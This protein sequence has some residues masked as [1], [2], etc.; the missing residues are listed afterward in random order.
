MEELKSAINWF[1]IPTIDF[2]RAVHFYSK[3]YDFEMPTRDMGHL[4]MGFFPH[5]PGQGIGG[6]IVSGDGYAPSQD[7][8][9]LYLN[10]GAD[11]STVLERVTD[12]GGLVVTGKTE[13]SPD[14]GHFAIIDDSEGNR[15]YLHSMN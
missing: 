15:V 2:D 13:I 10:G 3:I 9:K 11:L 6:A 8:V 12:A 1:E 4:K 14:I 5:Q 7:G